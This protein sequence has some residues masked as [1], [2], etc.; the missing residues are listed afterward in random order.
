VYLRTLILLCLAFAQE[1]DAQTTITRGASLSV[2]AAKDGRLA[3]DLL[4]DL[5]VVPG[6]GGEARQLTRNLKTVQGPRWSP[7]GD[8]LAYSA[9]ADGQQGVWVYDLNSDETKTLS[10]DASFDLHPSW[11]PD[12][13]RV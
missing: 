5:W 10:S 2:D 1:A 8:R 12:G 11:H 13:E 9:V 4:G 6:G 3:M 7:E